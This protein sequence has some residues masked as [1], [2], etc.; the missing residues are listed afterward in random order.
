MPRPNSA[1]VAGTLVGITVLPAKLT[2]SVPL[3]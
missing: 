3:K 1:A 2:S